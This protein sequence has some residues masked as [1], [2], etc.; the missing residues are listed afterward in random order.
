MVG[1]GRRVPLRF[2]P[3]F[4]VRGAASSPSIKSLFPGE[5]SVLLGKN[6]GGGIFLVEEILPVCIAAFLKLPQ[7]VYRRCLKDSN[8]H[9][10][11]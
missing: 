3:E 1:S 4:R 10:P 5:I 7:M 8:D 9:F 2:I 6:G 11:A